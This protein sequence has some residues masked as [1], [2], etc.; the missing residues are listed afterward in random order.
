MF[1]GARFPSKGRRSPAAGIGKLDG[2]GGIDRYFL[3]Y[4]KGGER[5]CGVGGTGRGIGGVRRQARSTHPVIKTGV[6]VGRLRRHRP[7]HQGQAESR[8]PFH[9]EAH[10][11][12]EKIFQFPD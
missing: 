12:V 4:P 6:M 9:A 5:R 11:L 1:N 8:K 2:D 10:L 7:Q 3:E